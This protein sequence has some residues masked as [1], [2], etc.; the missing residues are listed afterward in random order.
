MHFKEVDNLI[1][2]IGKT[3][4]HLEQSF[5]ARDILNDVT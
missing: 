2:V 5:F 4:G 1:I 3:E